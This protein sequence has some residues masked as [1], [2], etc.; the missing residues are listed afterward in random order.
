MNRLNFIFTKTMCRF[1]AGAALV[2]VLA[3]CTAGRIYQQGVEGMDEGRYEEAIQKLEEAVR[4]EPDNLKFRA[5][6]RTAREQ[7]VRQLLLE[8]ERHVNAGKY[9]VAEATYKR[10]LVV[11]P[12]SVRASAG[13]DQLARARQHAP[14][15]AQ[16]QKYFKEQNPN[17]ALGN[18]RRILA[19]NPHHA[20]AMALLQKIDE[21]QV[22]HAHAPI[23]LKSRYVKPVTLQF[24]DAGLRMVFEALSKTTGINFLFDNDVK[25]AQRLTIFVNDVSVEDAIDLILAQSQLAQKVLNDNTILIYP[26]TPAKLKEYQEQIIKSF[27]LTNIDPKKA[28]GM[29][30]TLLDAGTTY[31]DE[32]A[33][34][35]IL[36]DTPEVIRMAE[37]LFAAADLTEPEVMLEVEVIEIKRST[38]QQLGIDYPGRIGFSATNASGSTDKLTLSDLKNLSSSNVLVTPLSVAVDITKQ[39]S[40]TNVL[41]SPRIRARSKEKARIHIG[42]RV[43][44]ITNAV[45]PVSTGSPVVTGSVQYLDVGLKLEIEPT[46]YLDNEVAIKMNLEVS[47]IVKEVTNTQSG[48]VAYQIGT[49]NAA[50]LLRLKDGETQV[51]AGLISDEERNTNKKIPGL[52]DIPIL[53]KLFATEKNDNIKTEIVLSITPRLIRNVVRPDASKSEFW[54]GS[55]T[56]KLGRP[57]T[58]QSVARGEAQPIEAG[59]TVGAASANG[60]RASV[61]TES[62]KPAV[63]AGVPAEQATEPV[64]NTVPLVFEGPEKVTVGQKF[65]VALIV[66]AGLPINGM[67]AQLGY[68]PAV[69]EVVGVAGGSLT[70]KGATPANVSHQIDRGTGRIDVK[71]ASVD[72]PG[73][74]GTTDALIVTFVAIGAKPQSPITLEKASFL[75][76]D[77]KPLPGGMPPP[78]RLAANPL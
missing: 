40:D 2:L 14:L 70:R 78:L 19:E 53:G 32:K 4:L 10:L 21:A 71:I 62:S 34:L 30:K 63:V 56:R 44:V 49:R 11:E 17:A 76:A 46:V 38:L 52:G 68:D 72:G 35:L 65:E 47:S 24:R 33:N 12:A 8:A 36:R 61:A 23:R 5:K 28:Q 54:Y 9:E 50:T 39:D 37:N 55:E 74:A 58:V 29:L 60:E 73:Y 27:Y 75:G 6:L 45:T 3:G 69:F 1:L 64:D 59:P 57:L 42:D 16:A 13:L 15:L 31:I 22:R 18:V 26:S 66:K 43:P 7:A 20:E 51:L 48:S 25:N 41:A 77:G 67:T